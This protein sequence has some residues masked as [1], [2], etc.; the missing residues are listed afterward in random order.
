MSQERPRKIAQHYLKGWFAFD[1]LSCMPFQYITTGTAG[2][3]TGKAAKALRLV[4][5]AKMLRLARLKRII[6]QH[7]G[8]RYGL[9]S[10]VSG[11]VVLFLIIVYVGHLLAC[12]WYF[13]GTDN[14]TPSLVTYTAAVNGDADDTAAAATTTPAATTPT[15]I[16]QGW[17]QIEYCCSPGES[18]GEC[19]ASACSEADFGTVPLSERYV[20]SLYY[21]FN[22][23]EAGKTQMERGYAVFA[24]LCVGFIFGSLAG[25][26]SSL[27]MTL[28]GNEAE[29]ATNLRQ[30]KVWLE[31]KQLPMDQQNK[32]M[33]YFHST[34]MTNKQIDYSKLVAEMPPLMANSIVTKL[35]GRF[36]ETIPLFTGLSHE[37]IA[38]LCREV[39][40]MIAVKDQ[41]IMVE[42]QPG[43]ELFMLMKG[44][45]EMTKEGM[46]M[47]RKTPLFEPNICMKPI[48]STK[49]GSGQIFVNFLLR[50]ESFF[51]G[52]SGR[53]RILRRACGA[54]R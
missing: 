13:V 34:W 52:V 20:T 26:M 32:I 36:L 12:F 37:I 1:F 21:V 5:L 18:P 11:F 30:L 41:N 31:A 53:G 14:D 51:A 47:V 50:K 48:F 7:I 39:V 40:P 24:E 33:D 43:R 38:A 42:G 6:G 2:G 22:A 16:A 3:S 27:M 4:R 10:E 46:R 23:L 19:S 9:V 15:A 44:E 28:R 35:Y 8:S 54:E 29:I 17:V 45:V 49:T 25:L